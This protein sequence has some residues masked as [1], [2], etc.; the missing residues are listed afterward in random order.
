MQKKHFQLVVAFGCL[1]LAVPLILHDGFER[2][3]Y[4]FLLH[5]W[6]SDFRPIGDTVVFFLGSFFGILGLCF[7]F[8]GF[9]SKLW[10]RLGQ[11]IKDKFNAPCKPPRR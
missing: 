5:H 10:I 9:T 1:L 8:W 11:L 4:F 3:A 6:F 2:A 7:L